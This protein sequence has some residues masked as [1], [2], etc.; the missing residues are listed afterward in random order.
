MK[1]INIPNDFSRYPGLRFR[2]LGAYSGEEFRDSVLIPAL[3]QED[4]VSIELDGSKGYGSSF[5]E[6]A[7]G[8]A[9]RKGYQLTEKTLKL[10]SEDEYLIKEIWKYIKES[11]Q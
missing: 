5:L 8:G 11:R 10:I 9:V 6:E 3:E 1:T 2:R 4:I 7:F